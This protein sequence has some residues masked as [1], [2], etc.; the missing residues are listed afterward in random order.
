MAVTLTRVQVKMPAVIIIVLVI[1]VHLLP[2]K[3]VIITPIKMV[4]TIIII[5]MVPRKFPLFS[6]SQI[7]PPTE[8]DSFFHVRYLL[9]ANCVLPVSILHLLSIK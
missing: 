7:I 3:T 4:V 9:S 8:I 6:R 5:P 2:I 1:M